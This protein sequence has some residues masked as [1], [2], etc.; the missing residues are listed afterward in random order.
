VALTVFAKG[1]FDAKIRGLFLA[2][3]LDSSGSIDKKEL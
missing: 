1:E 2:F 3:D